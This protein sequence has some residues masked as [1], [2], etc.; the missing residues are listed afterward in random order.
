MG[1]VDLG[2][3][4]LE[5]QL[6]GNIKD[7]STYEWHNETWV[8]YLVFPK[9]RKE[10]AKKL[11][12]SERLR[13]FLGAFAYPRQPKEEILEAYHTAYRAYREIDYSSE[14][15]R[16]FPGAFAYPRQP[17]EEILEAYQTA[18]RAYREIDYSAEIRKRAGIFIVEKA[19]YPPD[20]NHECYNCKGCI[21]CESSTNCTKCV[22]CELCVGCFD[23]VD[24]V[25]CIGVTRREGAVYVIG[26]RQFYD[27][28]YILIQKLARQEAAKDRLR[29]R[30][31]MVLR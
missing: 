10:A 9:R 30:H 1:L 17:K 3:C 19:V 24:C 13:Q 16:Q 5:V 22:N 15:L 27:K 21:D 7:V 25:S 6:V 11:S 2:V 20:G 12:E 26:G 4:L 8:E 14:R 23:C 31:G 18:Y 29:S 28:T